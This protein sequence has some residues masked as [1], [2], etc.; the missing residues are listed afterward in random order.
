VAEL[1]AQMLRES[2]NGTAELL[3]K[4]L[5]A[6]VVGQGSSAAGAAVV[7]H[8]LTEAGL[9]MAGVKV[10][11]GSGLDRGN[12]VTCRLL[13]GLVAGTPAGSPVD[14]GLAVAGTSGTLSRRFVGTLAVGRLRAKTGSIRG[15]ASLAGLVDTQG[16]V[17]LTFAYV[18]NG[19]AAGQDVR[20]LQDRLADALMR[21]P[22]VP[23]LAE[24]GPD[25]YRPAA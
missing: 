6:R 15:V 25:G 10:V 24:L 1:V 3:L 7:T 16:G 13:L 4:E 2:D 9:P 19:V 18:L 11:D 8:T 17:N 12:S 14:K 5:G 22:D 21:Y 20:P 23:D